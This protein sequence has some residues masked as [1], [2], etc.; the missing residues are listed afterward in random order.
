MTASS[1]SGTPANSG[2]VFSCS[3]VIMILQSARA[4][5]FAREDAHKN[6][7][8]PFGTSSKNASS[9][10]HQPQLSPGSN[11]R[12]IGCCVFLKCALACLFFESS[13][14][15][16]CPQLKHSRKC[17]QLSPVRRHSSQPSAR[18]VT[19]RICSKC[20]QLSI[21]DLRCYRYSMGLRA[22]DIP[23]MQRPLLEGADR[24]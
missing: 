22:T 14:Q 24:S 18:G 15:P 1:R 5:L 6:P 11:E 7:V 16:T 13:Q 8:E 9:T 10:K 20:G 12:T 19:G 23:L 3:A 4:P 21:G 17:T 2:T